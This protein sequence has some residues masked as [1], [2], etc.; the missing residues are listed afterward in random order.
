MEQIAITQV[1]EESDTIYIE[2]K[3]VDV[4][5]ELS[6]A[7]ISDIGTP[8]SNDQV[9]VRDISAGNQLKYADASE[10]GGS[11]TGDMTKAV[12]DPQTIEADAF[13]RANHTGTQAQSTITNLTTDLAAKADGAA[14]S[15]D[16]A[17]ARYDG[18]T[19]KVL[20]NSSVTIDD[21][22]NISTTGNVDGRDISADGTKLDTIETNADVTDTANVTAAGAVMDSELTSE[23]GIKT[24]TV[25]DNLTLSADFTGAAGDI[26]SGTFADARIS[27]SS[28]TQHESALTIASSQLTGV[29][30]S[31]SIAASDETTDLTTGTAKA[32]FRMPFALTLTEVRASVTTAPVGSTIE[33]DLNEGG[34]SILST[35]ISIDANEKTS[36]TAATP[37]VISDSNLADD[38]EI[39]VD[40]DQVGSTTAGAGLKIYLIGTRA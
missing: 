6:N 21:S 7:T 3:E 38:A 10:F 29:V 14:S 31:V 18:T 8:A 35:V 37:P 19:G 28:V 15:T 32:T 40:L 27:E 13:D 4:V 16:N 34:V 23:T 12:Y 22:G 39:T 1:D 24:L 25:S 5:A 33:V 9:L 2:V 36:T 11:G 17:I 26:T 20:Q 30:A